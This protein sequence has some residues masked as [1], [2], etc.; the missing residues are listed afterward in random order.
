MG[1]LGNSPTREAQKTVKAYLH[2]WED[3]VLVPPT[4]D[5][6]IHT[7]DEGCEFLTRMRYLMGIF[8]NRR[9]EVVE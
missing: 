2:L 3:A 5:T 1:Q 4:S 8:P 7:H 9:V 6:H